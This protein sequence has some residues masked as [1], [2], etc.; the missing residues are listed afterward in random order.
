MIMKVTFYQCDGQ[1]GALIDNDQ[2]KANVD[3][4]NP[5]KEG[6]IDEIAEYMKGSVG[7]NLEFVNY[8]GVEERDDEE[9]LTYDEIID[10]ITGEGFTEHQARLIYDEKHLEGKNLK[11]DDVI[12]AANDWWEIQK[13]KE[14]C[15]IDY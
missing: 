2:S 13:D 4:T 6:L 8:L 15:G 14:R 1:Y 10:I 12:E 9:E 5:T 7:D 3:I 11:E